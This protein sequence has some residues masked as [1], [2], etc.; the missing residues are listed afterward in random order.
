MSD[1][2]CSLLSVIQELLSLRSIEVLG[3]RILFLT[4]GTTVPASRFRVGQ[5]LPYFRDR[6]LECVVRAGY[7][8]HYNQIAPTPLGTPYKMSKRLLRIIR[9]VDAAAFDVVFL[10]RPAVPHTPLPEQLI[11]RLNRRTIFDVDDAIFLNA[12]GTANQR[13]EHT[14]STIVDEVCHVICGNDF[15]AQAAAAPQKTTIIPTVIDCERYSPATDRQKYLADDKE[16][17]IGW[18]GTAGNFKSLDLVVPALRQVLDKHENTRF[19]VVSNAR[20]K[21]LA[22]H[23]QCE[24]IP[25]SADAE[26]DLLRSFDI[27]LMPLLDIPV[28]Y[29][30]CG[31]KMIQYMAV[32]T[33]VVSSSVGANIDIF[34]GS[35]AGFLA[36]NT[37]EWVQ[38]LELLINDALKRRRCG[39]SGRQHVLKNYSIRSVI[40][41]YM[42]LFEEVAQG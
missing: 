14:F 28:S 5:F 30:K 36:D 18:M 40:D 33:A 42:A 34:E 27:G 35:G 2:G 16:L 22:D 10:Q 8:D 1:N 4:E 41:Q 21:P 12:D 11:H 6:G 7:G 20:F 13:Y 31:F 37:A 24:S 23:P 39:E 38:A 19:R 29:G 26:I 32:G 9:S 3:M 15:L 17:I 25:W